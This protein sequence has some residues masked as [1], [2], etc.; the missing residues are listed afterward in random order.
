MSWNNESKPLKRSTNGSKNN[1]RIST[2]ICSKV[3]QLKRQYD[4]AAEDL[5]VWQ[6]KKKKAARHIKYVT[7]A[8]QH[9]EEVAS[10]VQREWYNHLGSVVTRCIQSVF[11]PESY[12]FKL[13]F[14]TK[15]HRTQ[16]S[17]LFEKDGEDYDPLTST[18]GG[19][20]DVAA[21]ALRI[22]AMMISVKDTNKILILDE[23]FRFVSAEYRNHIQT[24]L[25]VLSEEFDMQ[26][27]MI[28][29]MPEVQA[30]SV[31]PFG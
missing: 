8:I 28:T 19:V 21:F 3:E 15:A 10:A 14:K 13:E 11:G 17:L 25:N 30:G 27:L 26:I 2:E 1:G 9:L 7:E 12:K 23:P 5:C 20:V 16:V 29:H 6:K 18:G 31:V 24:L 4:K 22:A